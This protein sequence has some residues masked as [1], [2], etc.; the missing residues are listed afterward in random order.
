MLAEHRALSSE[1][2]WRFSVG[3][4]PVDTSGPGIEVAACISSQLSALT[5]S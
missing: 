1:A 2:R 4:S 3:D 5:L